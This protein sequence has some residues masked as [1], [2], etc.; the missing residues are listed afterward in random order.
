MGSATNPFE[1]T[2]VEINSL[3]RFVGYMKNVATVVDVP[4]VDHFNYLRE[5]LTHLV[6]EA[7]NE[8]R[9]LRSLFWQT[10]QDDR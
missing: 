4:Y 7:S 10:R 3:P 2:T 5:F 1:N 9:I 6:P 8:P